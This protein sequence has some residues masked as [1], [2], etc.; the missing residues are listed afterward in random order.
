MNHPRC[1]LVDI[2][3]FSR[4]NFDDEGIEIL[5][6][7]MFLENIKKIN[8]SSSQILEASLQRLAQC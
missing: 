5:R 2:F 8:L 7:G 4:I 1:L 3:D 6:N